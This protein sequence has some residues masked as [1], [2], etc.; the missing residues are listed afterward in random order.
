MTNDIY[1]HNSLIK[2]EI[3]E[4]KN[5]GYKFFVKANDK[6]MPGWGLAKDKTHIQIVLCKNIDDV[7]KMMN[8]FKNDNSFN[9]ANFGYLDYKTLYNCIRNKSFSIRNKWELA[10]VGINES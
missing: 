7:N 2:E 4:C 8:Y 10:G 3:E 5:L 9:Y 6:F 1:M